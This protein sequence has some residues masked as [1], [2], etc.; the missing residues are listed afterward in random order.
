MLPISSVI[1]VC[2]CACIHGN[3]VCFE[4]TTITYCTEQL[5]LAREHSE[6]TK[7]LS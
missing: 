4:L 2:A 6:W 7:A 5:F 1:L 3:N